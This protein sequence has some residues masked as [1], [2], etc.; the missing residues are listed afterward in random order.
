MGQQSRDGRM[1]EISAT[2]GPAAM[3][4]EQNGK[5]DQ[6]DD[7]IA[8]SPGPE[9]FERSRLA[10]LMRT[11]GVDSYDALLAWAAAD[12]GRYWATAVAHLGLSWAKPYS[13]A[14]DLSHGAP[15]AE[16]FV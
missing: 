16:W 1:D 15:W 14:L 11:A 8:W 7:E 3:A 6:R 5:H 10:D 9:Q 2:K 4:S 13:E 12:P